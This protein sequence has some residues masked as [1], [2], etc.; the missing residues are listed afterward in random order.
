MAT[1]KDL[2][3][4]YICE[5]NS[6]RDSIHPYI[7]QKCIMTNGDL[8]VCFHKDIW[9]KIG[10]NPT[11]PIPPTPTYDTWN[12]LSTLSW[13]DVSTFKWDELGVTV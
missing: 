13:N 9:S 11:P 10:E 2:D 1:V 6:D 4:V 3:E 7:G 8:Y 12:S 5:T